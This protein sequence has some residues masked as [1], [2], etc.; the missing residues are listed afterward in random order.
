MSTA[1]RQNTVLSILGIKAGTPHSKSCRETVRV[2]LAKGFSDPQ[3]V[4][5]VRASTAFKR[6]KNESEA[7]ETAAAVIMREL[8]VTGNKKKRRDIRKVVLEQVNLG[9]PV[10]QAV[11]FV[12]TTPEWAAYEAHQV[13]LAHIEALAENRRRDARKAKGERVAAMPRHLRYK[14]WGTISTLNNAYLS[15]SPLGRH[16][17]LLE[18]TFL[19]LSR[20]A[21][22]CQATA[23]EANERREAARASE[24]RSRRRHAAELARRDKMKYARLDALDK[25]ITLQDAQKFVRENMP[26]YLLG[27]FREWFKREYE[28]DLGCL[29]GAAQEYLSIR[30]IIRGRVALIDAVPTAPSVVTTPPPIPAIEPIVMATEAIIPIKRHGKRAAYGAISRPDQAAFSADVRDNCH[31]RCVVTGARSKRRCEAAHL[32]EHCRNGVD[33]WSNGLWLRID[34]HRLFDA[35][36]CAINP[37]TLCIHFAAFVL[38]DD[39]DLRELEGQ[40]IATTIKPI[41]PQYLLARWEAFVAR[42]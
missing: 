13:E 22:K 35:N 12:K 14:A 31:G 9:V 42:N 16:M 2:F 33:H 30:G 41:N 25:E 1:T 23:N 38:A 4:E 17:S 19:E 32:I 7:S 36:E 37:H 29:L 11:A 40:R 27:S 3:V 21:Q 6:W 34:I 5:K 28:G 24:E 26:D 20:N 15:N 8:S 10:A 39:E 18:D